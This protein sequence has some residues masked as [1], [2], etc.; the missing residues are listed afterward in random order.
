MADTYIIR[1]TDLWGNDITLTQTRWTEHII[2]GHPEVEGQLRRIERTVMHPD[3]V[4]EQAERGTRIYVE[5]TTFSNYFN[6]L[7]NSRTGMVRTIYPTRNII[8][9]DIIYTRRK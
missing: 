3:I 2:T 1:V 5:D 9:G 8:N 4:I 7:T 6:V